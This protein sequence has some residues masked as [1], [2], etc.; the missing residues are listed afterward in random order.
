[1]PCFVSLAL[2]A[3]SAWP[4]DPPPPPGLSL[5]SSSSS[6]T[7]PAQVSV[8]AWHFEPSDKVRAVRELAP[9]AAALETVLARLERSFEQQRHFVSDAAHELKTSVAVIK[10]TLQLLVMK[11]RSAEDYRAGLLR[12]EIDCE[13]MEQLV[14][15]MLTL[16]GLEAASSPGVDANPVDLAELLSDVTEQFRSFAESLN[17]GFRPLNTPTRVCVTGEREKLR[18]LCSNLIHN[19][20]QHSLSGAEVRALASI[21]AEAIELRIEDDGEGIPSEA[22]PHVFERFYRGDVSRSRK[23]GGTGLGL[24]ISKAIVQEM[25]GEITIESRVNQGTIV[26]MH[27]P[28]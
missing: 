16:A 20:L 22:L 3:L 8:D 27:F 12:A 4:D 23:T 28:R 15:S 6:P 21:T 14:A 2:F 17:V 1:M 11:D 25:K 18:L 26:I 19:A 10:S 13:R 7:Q 9:L 24:S 5:R